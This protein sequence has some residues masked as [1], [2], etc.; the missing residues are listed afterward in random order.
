MKLP[1]A[2]QQEDNRLNE[3]DV[4]LVEDIKE[5]DISPSNSPEKE[6]AL[7]MYTGVPLR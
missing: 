3:F 1:S 5:G 4:H 6:W 7:L 2:G